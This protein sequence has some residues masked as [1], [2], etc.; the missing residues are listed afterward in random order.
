MKKLLVLVL[1]LAACGYGASRGYDWLSYEV[2][3]PPT[4]A[5]QPVPFKVTTGEDPDAIASDLQSKGLIRSKD[6][7]VYYLRYTGARSRL[8]AGDYVLNRNMSMEAIV[9]A[10]QHGR[11]DQVTVT[12]P[13]G[14]TLALMAKAAEQ[15]GLGKAADYQ[16]AAS[17]PSWSFGF[18]A[19]RPKGRNLEGYLFP[20]TYSLNK[21]STTKD[22]VQRQLERF[23]QAFGP[24]LQA[25]AAKPTAARP[26]ESVDSI[27]ILASM[28]EREVNRDPDRA[29]VCGIYYNRLSIGMALQV[30]ATV[31]YAK[32]IWKGSVTF[33]DLKVDSPYNTY[34]NPGLPPG[35][36]ANP[37][38]AALKACVEPQ[39]TDYLYYF[40]DP[41][42]V[43]HFDRTLAE[44]NQDQQ[45]YGVSGG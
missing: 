2:H 18:L 35:P 11:A 15:A 25:E 33:D 19:S 42:G 5:S 24:D 17:D 7:F 23:G 22:L 40:T 21:G 37:G 12:M 45:K 16:A 39:K 1:L 32:G 27:V 4:T 20:D 9:A 30:D 34:R 31:L 43:T 26:A 28:V 36:I 44:F 13:E 3:T 29:I 10:L 14:Y 6:V 8:Q 38:A 41:K